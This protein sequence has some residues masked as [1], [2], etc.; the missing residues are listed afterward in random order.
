M[1][2]LALAIVL[3]LPN[4][5]FTRLQ[6]AN[7]LARAEAEGKFYLAEPEKLLYSEEEALWFIVGVHRLYRVPQPHYIHK[8][9]TSSR[10]AK[11]LLRQHDTIWRYEAG[12]YIA[13]AELYDKLVR[14]NGE[15]R[16][17]AG[18]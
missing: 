2:V 10:E 13:D 6:W 8:Y 1:T 17:T 9:F 5:E 16:S 4:T 14:M 11:Q 15:S 18:E 12:T 3:M 7:T